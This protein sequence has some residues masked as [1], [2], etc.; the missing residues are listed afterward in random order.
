MRVLKG[1]ISLFLCV[2]MTP[3]LTIALLLV[4]M[5]KYNSAVSILDESMGVSSTSLLANYDSYLHDR[6]GLLAVDQKVDINSKYN[7]YLDKNSGVLGNG[8][9]IDKATAKGEYPLSDSEMLYKQILEFSKLNAPTTLAADFSNLSDLI[10]KLEDFANIGKLFD[11][12]GS[13]TDAVDSSITI[14]E[15]AN[16]LKS[17]AKDLEGLK[18]EYDSTYSSFK[19]AVDRLSSALSEPRPKEEEAA[20]EY[21]NNISSLK[22]SV[23]SAASSYSSVLSQIASKLK[24]FKDKMTECNNS[25]ESIKNDIQ[26]AVDNGANIKRNRKQKED[27]LTSVNKKITD[28]KT[29]HQDQDDNADYKDQ[30]KKKTQLEEEIADASAKEGIASATETGLKNVSEG[31]KQSF[32]KYSDSTIGEVIKGF[33]ELQAKVDGFSSGSVGAGYTLSDSS[34]HNVSVAGYIS[35]EDIDGYI[36]SQEDDLK[37]GSLSALIDGITTFFNSI[38]K[39]QLFY[40]PSLSSYID[41]N[42]YKSKL[43]GLPGDDSANGGVLAVITDIGSMMKAV[44]DFGSNFVSLKWIKALGAI[45]NLIM[46]IRDFGR[47]LA[48]FAIGICKNIIGLFKSYDRLYYTTYSTFNLPCRTDFTSGLPS[49]TAMTGYKFSKDTTPQKMKGLNLSP[50]DDLKALIDTI[51]SASKGTGSDLTFSGAELEYVLFGSNSEIAN[52]MYTFATLYLFRLIM[53]IPAVLSNV[54]VQSLAAS[55][56]LGYPVVMILEIIAEPLVDTVL[57]V[58]GSEVPFYETEIYL[59]P[60]GIVSVIEEMVNKCKLTSEQK[61]AVGDKIIDAFGSSKNNYDYQKSIKTHDTGHKPNKTLADLFKFNYREYCFIIMLLTVTK[62][63]QMGRL[64][65]LI[66]MESLYYYNKQGVSYV[67]DLK[68]SYTYIESTAKVKVKQLMPSLSDASVFTVDRKQ[69]RGY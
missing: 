69:Y 25:M 40:D 68:H 26:S 18:S 36:N 15:A 9:T 48:N 58:N 10:D 27:D 31:W 23:D 28:M 43:G 32:N 30:L 8:L 50:V 56:T 2:L 34:Y 47:D 19:S 22:S 46:S 4:E 37:N 11:T 7:T 49:F 55:T 41:V 62:E 42:Y 3:F 39:T 13:A 59:T 64:Q 21:D 53:D 29:N 65:N 67:F 16:E 66:Q 44:K 45:K 51:K 63:Q 38:I 1:S 57:L 5:G 54:E 24:T 14:S 20:K 35:A 61:S 52:Q 12:I 17:T 6:W 60:S 33:N